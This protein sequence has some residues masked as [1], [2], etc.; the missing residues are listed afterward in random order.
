MYKLEGKGNTITT[1]EQVKLV[2][3][4]VYQEPVRNLIKHNRGYLLGRVNFSKSINYSKFRL[5]LVTLSLSCLT[6]AFAVCISTPRSGLAA[7][8]DH[9]IFIAPT[10]LNLVIFV[11]CYYL[12]SFRKQSRVLYFLNTVDFLFW[13]GCFVARRQNELDRVKRYGLLGVFIISP[14][15]KL[16][17][18]G[19]IA[20]KKMKRKRYGNVIYG[21]CSPLTIVYSVQRC[22]LGMKYFSLVHQ[23]LPAFFL[24]SPFSMYI[25]F[26]LIHSIV[27][28][29][30]KKKKKEIRRGVKKIFWFF[31]LLISLLSSDF[32]FSEFFNKGKYMYV[33]VGISWVVVSICMFGF[34]LSWFYEN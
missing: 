15:L 25:A 24:L 26:M 32:L 5:I 17:V 34:L 20:K 10:A 33:C 28:T 1:I 21:Y 8:I 3:E 22:L 23:Y 12:V 31:F 18:L 19:S 16:L 6:F 13:Y 11:D 14:F 2:K 29:C 27:K 9:Y 30:Q 4:V 7:F